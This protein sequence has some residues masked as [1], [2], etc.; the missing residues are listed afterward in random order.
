MKRE[1]WGEIRRFPHKKK[2]KEFVITKPVL[3]QKLRGLLSEEEEEVKENKTRRKESDNERALHTNPSIIT[4][5][6]NGLNAPTKRHKVAKW[7]R[8][9]D[10]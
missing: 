7:I 1:P 6:P 8:K 5:N 3:Q 2:L 4:L 10:P 9:Q